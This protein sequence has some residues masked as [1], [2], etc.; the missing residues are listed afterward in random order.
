MKD[1]LKIKGV[2]IQ[3]REEEPERFGSYKTRDNSL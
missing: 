2:F 3:N 1:S